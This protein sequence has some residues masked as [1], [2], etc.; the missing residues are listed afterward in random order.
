M[1]GLYNYCTNSWR[2]I[3]LLLTTRPANLFASVAQVLAIEDF[4]SK[5]L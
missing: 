2:Q 4:L 1:M 5:K 3:I